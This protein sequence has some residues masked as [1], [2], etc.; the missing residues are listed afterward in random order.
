MPAAA[1]PPASYWLAWLPVPPRRRLGPASWAAHAKVAAN[2][3]PPSHVWLAWRHPL[4]LLLLLLLLPLPA[5]ACR[6]L[7]LLAADDEACAAQG[8]PGRL[9]VWDRF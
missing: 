1:R 7:L 3:A 8:W 9:V 5:A 2:G 4:L 6:C